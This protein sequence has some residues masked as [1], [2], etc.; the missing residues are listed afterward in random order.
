MKILLCSIGTRGDIEPFLA[1][2]E[3]LQRA[4]HEV[5]S[6]FPD[7]LRAL[8]EDAGIKSYSL[9]PKFL[10]LLEG[11]AGKIAMGG[12]KMNLKKL[13]AY[14]TLIAQQSDINKEMI[15]TQFRIIE[16]I[17]PDRILHSAKAMYP[18]IWGMQKKGKSIFISPVPY[19]HYVKDHAHIGFNRNFGTFIN[20]LTYK[21]AN[22]A[23]IRT[24]AKALKKLEFSKNISTK[25]IQKALF[26]ENAIYTISPSLFKRPE[27]WNKNL[28]VLG[29]HE[30]TKYNNWQATAQLKNFIEKHP[31]LALVTFGSMINDKPEQKTRIILDILE[32][33]NIPAIINTSSGGLIEPK[34]YN[35]NLFHFVKSI[36]YDWIF[37]KLYA[38]IHHG[39][40]GTTHTALKYAC[41]NLIIPHIIDQYVWN[42]L[43][44]KMGSGPLG[45]DVKKISQ[46]GLSPKIESLWNDA[47]FKEKAEEIAL[48]MSNEDFQEDIINFIEQ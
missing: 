47:R 18:L 46:K 10:D 21:L 9:G 17:N 28:Q 44:A 11:P 19:L 12:G 26:S 48:K 36:P 16:E 8:S 23:L 43:N 34:E 40:S 37:P 2:G 35:S 24:T 13:K 6:L 7:Q 39:G 27:Y 29:Y 32:E 20:K 42:S 33:K 38:V 45:I 4:G 41:A 25:Q 22:F 1:L 15:E 3:L 14:K 30:R 5:F 31:K